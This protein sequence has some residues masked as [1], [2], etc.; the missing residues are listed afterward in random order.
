LSGVKIQSQAP[1]QEIY[2]SIDFS[3]DANSDITFSFKSLRDVSIW[4]FKFKAEAET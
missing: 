4:L 1:N 3:L 2:N